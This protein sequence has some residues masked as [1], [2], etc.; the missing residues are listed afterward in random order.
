MNHSTISLQSITRMKLRF[1]LKSAAIL[2][3]DRVI[4]VQPARLPV[5]ESPRASKIDPTPRRFINDPPPPEFY[6]KAGEICNI[7]FW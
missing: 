7:G 6:N 1:C 3:I 2:L 4:G 5:N